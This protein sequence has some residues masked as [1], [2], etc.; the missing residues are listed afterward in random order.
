MSNNN[1]EGY[2][3]MSLLF[4]E[5]PVLELM[6]EQSILKGNNQRYL[7]VDDCQADVPPIPSKFFKG[8]H[9][10]ILM[11]GPDGKIFDVSNP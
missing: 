1:K 7:L 3:G 5:P 9:M 8:R 6:L 10:A 4:P 11:V 2:C